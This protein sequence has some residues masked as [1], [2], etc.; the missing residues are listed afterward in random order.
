M[1]PVTL[2]RML[3]ID[4]ENV[5]DPAKVLSGTVLAFDFG[6]RRIGIAVGEHLIRSANPL[7][8]IDN[9]SNEVR[10]NLITQLVNEWQPKL[11]VVGLPLSLDGSETEVTQLC[12][13]FAR[14]LN[15]RFNLPVVLID[16]RYSSV[17]ASQLLNQSGIKGRAQKVML[18]QV[19]AQTILQSYFDGLS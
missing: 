8:T 2:K 10:F 16:E 14:R 5:Y 3:L 1:W 9:E 7:T 4:N 18:D 17:E 19:A 11:L 15:G 6:E 12:K 13:K